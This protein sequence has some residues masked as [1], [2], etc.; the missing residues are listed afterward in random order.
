MPAYTNLKSTNA[1]NRELLDHITRIG[2]FDDNTSPAWAPVTKSMVT[3]IDGLL[4]IFI[5]EN[6]TY[7]VWLGEKLGKA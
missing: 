4:K 5:A 6:Q 7:F 1:F 3:E 2:K